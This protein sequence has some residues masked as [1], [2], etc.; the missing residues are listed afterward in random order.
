MYCCIHILGVVLVLASCS[1]L[2]HT[3]TMMCGLQVLVCLDYG[4]GII[5]GGDFGLCSVGHVLQCKH[6][7]V[8]VYNPTHPHGTT[9]FELHPNE[10]ESG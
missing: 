1:G 9:K 8:I 6:G 7:Y 3:L 4:R 5:G 2:D 10:P